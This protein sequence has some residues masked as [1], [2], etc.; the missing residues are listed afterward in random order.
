MDRLF[1]MRAMRQEN[2]ATSAA[3]GSAAFPGAA[4]DDISA[5]QNHKDRKAAEAKRRE[6]T[7]LMQQEDYTDKP[8]GLERLKRQ[9]E[10]SRMQEE[11]LRMARLLAAERAQLRELKLL[12]EKQEEAR[13]REFF[14][15]KLAQERAEQERIAAEKE[16]ARKAALE[17]KM[18]ALKEA[19]DAQARA[20][21]AARQRE[22]EQ[23][24]LEEKEHHLMTVEAVR[25]ELEDALGAALRQQLMAELERK[26]QIAAEEAQWKAFEAQEAQKQQEAT[27]KRRAAQA[28]QYELDRKRR[29]EIHRL[30]KE[31]AG[32]VERQQRKKFEPL[33]AKPTPSQQQ[34]LLA[35]GKAIAPEPDN[36]TPPD[37]AELLAEPTN[38]KNGKESI[39]GASQEQDNPRQPEQEHP[40][41]PVDSNESADPIDRVIPD[42]GPSEIH[43]EESAVSEEKEPS[44]LVQESPNDSEMLTRNDEASGIADEAPTDSSASE[45][46]SESPPLDLTTAVAAG[47]APFAQLQSV[48]SGSPAMDAT[49]QA[50]DLLVQFGGITRSTPQC[51]LAIADC[52]K[53][54]VN[55]MIELSILRPVDSDEA[56]LQ[57]FRQHAIKLVP[58]KW[59][60]GKGLLGCNLSAFKLPE[61][62]EQSSSATSVASGDPEPSQQQEGPVFSNELSPSLMLVLHDVQPK[63]LAELVGIRDGDLLMGCGP[64][65]Q[66]D[67]AVVVDYLQ[68]MRSQQ[69]VPLDI[70]RWLPN[71]QQYEHVN[72]VLPVSSDPLGCALTTYAEYYSTPE[73][74]ASTQAQSAC[75]ECYYTTLATALH[76]A[77]LN[78]HIACLEA[79]MAAAECLTQEGESNELDWRDEDGRTPLFYASYAQQRECVEFLLSCMKT[80][81][82]ANQIDNETL[83]IYAG[84]E[85]GWSAGCDL[86]GDTPLHAAASN[87]S[88]EILTLLL[89]SGEFH[90]N[91]VNYSQVASVHLAANVATLQLLCESF[92]ADSLAVDAEGRMPLAFAVLRGDTASVDY[93]C[94]RH[95][96]FCDYADA[97]GDTPL[98]L[99]ASIGHEPS[100]QVLLQYLPT[101]ALFMPNANDL[102]AL[103]VA[104]A[105]GWT[106]LAELLDRAMNQDSAFPE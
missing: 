15:V 93:L 72:V 21:Y 51:L 26:A 75:L 17:L 11:E 57:L 80:S 4:N 37:Q 79:L 89:Q 34:E 76:A 86:Y 8:E 92:E 30:Q 71:D 20:E 5:A 44:T 25:M 19:A 77:A 90:A 103:Q 41:E 42:E 102:N 23:Q 18:K 67:L 81:K 68:Q 87:G 106:S 31:R 54:N 48:T 95:P 40:T 60:G 96:D 14:M 74:W 53:H 32:A 65:L 46:L 52:V 82:P 69:E 70:Q 24:E 35:T 2:H 50:G 55:Q 27:M 98:H 22:K 49:L 63:S 12:A 43:S 85:S 66:G 91:L 99:A 97:Q 6:E 28:E 45:P 13:M 104:Q 64:M 61:D 88:L 59:T 56:Q 10:R 105:N 38:E 7:R 36:Q 101:I 58:H 33:E 16:A 62:A 100:A 84:Q 78:G 39:V 47:L 83:A 1:V 3:S 9:E 94:T 29:I 73:A